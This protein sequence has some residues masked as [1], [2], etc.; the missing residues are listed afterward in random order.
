[1][2]PLDDL[3]YCDVFISSGKGLF[4]FGKILLAVKNKAPCTLKRVSG[5]YRIKICIQI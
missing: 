1:M 2:S 4:I 5:G 3:F